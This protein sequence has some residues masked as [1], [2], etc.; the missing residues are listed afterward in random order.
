MGYFSIF[1]HVTLLYNALGY[2]FPTTK[3]VRKIT[4]KYFKIY[5]P[6]MTEERFFNTNDNQCIFYTGG[7]GEI[8][9]EIYNS[10][11][12]KLSAHNL[13]V[14]IINK[15]IKNNHILIKSITHNKATTL[16]A[17]SSGAI[18]AL[19]TCNYLDNIEKIILLDPV[20]S[21]ILF[22][23]EQ[24]NKKI[25]L[26]YPVE[27]IL[28][29]NAKK[30]YQWKW[31][32]PKMPFVPIGALKPSII[33]VPNQNTIIAEKFGHCDILDYPWGKFMHQTFAEGY[34]DRDESTME[35]YHEW[36]ANVIATY[37]KEKKVID[38]INI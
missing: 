21:R 28:F 8:P 29:I 32:P 10:F 26:N 35:R 13:T 38:T 11:L 12:S 22:D 30:S 9:C 24:F 34:P 14:N 36:L 2:T 19:N 23:N 17:H 6:P 7:N 5:E 25:Y 15:E 1:M 16:I 31:F 33:A 4:D 27:D 18:E 3:G 37:I 20:D